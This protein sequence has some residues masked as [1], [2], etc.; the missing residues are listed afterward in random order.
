MKYS[1]GDNVKTV[2]QNSNFEE[3]QW[4]TVGTV[5]EYGEYSEQYLV[6]HGNGARCWYHSWELEPANKLI[7]LELTFVELKALVD[8]IDDKASSYE[9]RK[10][11]RTYSELYHKL[12]GIA[13]DHSFGEKSQ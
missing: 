7:K 8:L 9:D 12:V 4:N 6:E 1:A 13:N 3:A 5:R 2:K 11:Y 10:V